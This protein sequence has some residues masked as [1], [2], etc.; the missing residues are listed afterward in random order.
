MAD[1]VRVGFEGDPSDLVSAFDRGGD[2]AKGMAADIDR[3]TSNTRGSLTNLEGGID[4]SQQKF[5]GFSDTI[6]GT[7]DIMEGFRT[8]NLSQ[9]AIG[10]ADLAGGIVDFAIPAL[11]TMAGNLKDKVGPALTDSTTHLQAFTS[12]GNLAAIAK[13]AGGL[14]AV[15]LVA[16]GLSQVLEKI[17][18]LDDL[19]PLQTL[20]DFADDPGSLGFGDFT[21]GTLKSLRKLLPFHTGGIVG[22]PAGMQVPAVLQGGE[23]VF[24]GGSPGGR[25]GGVTI[26]V[27]GSV[28]TERDLGRIVA[29][30]LRD[31]GTKGIT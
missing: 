7:G 19:G 21:K 12:A 5:R 4:G 27:A 1:T 14:G 11:K 13:V 18:G 17:T 9:M 31:N 26:Y 29:D 23:P 10:F 20:K 22:G 8:G 6:E 15:L 2:A 3:A 30:A 16:E 28:I 25:G 24:P